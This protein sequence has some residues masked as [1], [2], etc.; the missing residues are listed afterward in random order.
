MTR[1]IPETYS[2]LD[3]MNPFFIPQRHRQ[4]RR[5]EPEDW[6]PGR[7]VFHPAPKDVPPTG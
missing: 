5:V 1:P 6:R 4:P 3:L 7:R 2:F